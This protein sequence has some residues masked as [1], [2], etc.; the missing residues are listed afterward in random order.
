[1]Y[2]ETCSCLTCQDCIAGDHRDHTHNARIPNIAKSHRENISKLL[3]SAQSV[4]AK[5]NGA[6]ED[7]SKATKRVKACEKN[8]SKTIRETFVQLHKALDDKMEEVLRELHEIS[9]SKT[10]ALGLQKDN[11]QELKKDIGQ[12]SS[13]ATNIIQT[14]TDCEIIA[15]GQLPSVELQ[16]CITKA[17]S[18][19]LIP[20]KKTDVKVELHNESISNICCLI[21][22]CPE[23][24]CWTLEEPKGVGCSSISRYGFLSDPRVHAGATFQLTA[25]VKDSHK[26]LYPYAD[27]VCLEAY[28]WHPK[29]HAALRGW[30]DYLSFSLMHRSNKRDG[31]HTIN[32]TPQTA[33][34]Y[35]LCITLNGQHIKNSPGY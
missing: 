32:F 10:A 1:M 24:S 30:E 34:R 22:L 31:I 5:L 29:Q 33:A 14:Y 11:F 13:I 12:C 35:K 2:C 8:V 17:E 3:T 19:S 23:E 27:D 18:V 26:A 16:S 21:D 28:L 7:N 20:C 15:L 25:E 9:L 4:M 6:V